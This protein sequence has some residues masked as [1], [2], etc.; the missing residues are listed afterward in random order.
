VDDYRM[1]V[2]LTPGS[3]RARAIFAGWVS[4]SALARMQL[5]AEGL[6]MI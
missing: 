5:A 6:E 1:A 4:S 3:K 2:A